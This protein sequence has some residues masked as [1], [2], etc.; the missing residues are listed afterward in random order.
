MELSDYNLKFIHIKGINI[1]L[2]DTISRLKL[3]DIYR[4]PLE[5]PKTFD[6]VKCFL[7][8]V[9]TDIQTLSIHNLNTEQKKD[10]SYRNSAAQSHHKNKN[11]FNPVTI[12]ANDLLQKQQYI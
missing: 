12:Y 10:I 1:I 4:E 11:S 6:T 9:T 2:A 3:L 5:N 8:M 7:E